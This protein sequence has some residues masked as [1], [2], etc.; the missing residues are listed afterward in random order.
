MKKLDELRP[1]DEVVLRGTVDVKA[2]PSVWVILD[3][4]SIGRVVKLPC[5][6]LADVSGKSPNYGGSREQ[7]G[8]GV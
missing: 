2:G 6:V 5:D 3:G 1:G 4:E 8:T 7:N